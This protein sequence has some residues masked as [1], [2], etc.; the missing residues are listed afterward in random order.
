MPDKKMIKVCSIV[1]PALTVLVLAVLL[2]TISR[3][4]DISV[5][6]TRSSSGFAAVE[7]VTETELT[8]ED[9]PIGVQKEYT[10]TLGDA[11][12]HDTSLAFYTV[13]Q[14]VTV[15]LDGEE[16]YS[17]K[18]A[19]SHRFTKTVGSNWVMIPLYAADSG[20][21]VK[22]DIT[23]AYE[24]FR[25]REVTF[26]IGSPLAIYRNRLAK[27][28]PQIILGSI[29]ILMG[30][31]FMCVA[32]YSLIKKRP[33]K[34]LAVLGIF[35]VML[36]LWRL[37]DTRFTPFMDGGQPVLF[38][39]IAITMPMLGMLPLVQWTKDS[40]SEKGR[41][42]ISGYETGI[43]MLCLLQFVLQWLRIYDL[44]ESMTATHVSMG[45]GAA[46]LVGLAVKER[47][48]NDGNEKMSLQVRLAF[49]CVAGIL[50]DVAAFY[51]KGNSSGLLF[52]LMA[53]VIYIMIM[54]VNTM[55]EYSR[56]QV[57]IAKLD[58]ELAQ[59]D[60]ELA[61]SERQVAQQNREL[62]EKER[63]LTDSR[64]KLM[65]SQIRSHFIFN[66]LTTI[67]TYCKIDAKMA[68]KALI[69]FSR[70][71]RRNIHIIEVDGLI[72]FSIELEQLEDYVELE[73][74]RFGDRIIFAT[75]I[76]TSSFKIPP[77]TV[78]PLVENAIKHGLVKKEEGGV[79][80]LHTERKENNIVI[81]VADDGVGFAPGM[82]EKTDSVGIKNVRYRLENMT[83]G[84]LDIE[85][86]P[87][88]GTTVTI[89]IPQKGE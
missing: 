51:I 61:K 58:R 14:Y 34:R 53:F 47:K 65:M 37:M 3:T 30:I 22:V 4:E 52:S 35:S 19:G 59:K 15:Y 2:V 81:T 11:I 42:V 17:L 68:D 45:T 62:A 87:G 23:P 72:D 28:L 55:F 56:Q 50:A 21:Q 86:E 85:S 66:V 7:N 75:D 20:K 78:Q 29:A 25:N 83:G 26:L 82:L 40:F 74:L 24:S 60:R 9:A 32:G 88:N 79:I 16:I 44:R 70:Y 43:A 18:P 71:L 84:T 6:G 64:I 27:D 33:G 31:T 89:K 13:H 5:T 46:I 69:R 10:F 1:L 76:E 73:K 49:L 39:Y 63:R 57:Q 77:L 41:K 38:Y 48:K 8:Q 36:G 80:F 54:G 12:L 67:S